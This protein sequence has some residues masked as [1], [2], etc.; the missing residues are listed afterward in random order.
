MGG[1]HSSVRVLITGGTGFIGRRLT[2]AALARGAIVFVLTRHPEAAKAR[3]LALAGA[4]LLL[5]DVTD[6]ESVRRALEVARPQRLFHNA[7]WYELGI[8]R[9][10]RRQ[11]RAVN[12][13]G[14]ENVLSLAAELGVDRVIYTSSTTALGDTGGA[15]ADEGFQRCAP[16]TSWYEATKADA[17][18]LALRHQQ[19]GEPVVIVAPAQVVGSGDH[20]PFGVMARLFLRGRLPPIGWAP[21]GAFTFAHVDDVADGMLA[22]GER[23]KPGEL[24]FLAGETLTLRELMRVWKTSA[25]RAPVWLWL[26]RPVALAMAGLTAPVLRA[27]GRTAFISPEVVRSGFVSFRYSSA[28]AIADLG[29]TFRSAEQAWDETLRTE[30]A[31]IRG[32]PPAATR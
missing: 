20:S 22:A 31:V 2:A 1:F 8:P 19:A 23:G 18:S 6:R 14:V 25:G 28:K 17:H 29:V 30:R 7:G 13:D 5:G 15:V 3:T 11:M 32:E 16:V 24:Y 9:R 21:Q 26:P 27:S 10:R 4:R 12:V